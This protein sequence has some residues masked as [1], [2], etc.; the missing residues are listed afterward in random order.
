MNDLLATAVY[1]MLAGF[2]YQ[3]TKGQRMMRW[4]AK[5][6]QRTCNMLIGDPD[7]VSLHV[8][9]CYSHRSI[10]VTVGLGNARKVFGT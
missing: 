9:L 7:G 2:E 6:A 10:L 8:T 4:I 3:P 1:R 5:S